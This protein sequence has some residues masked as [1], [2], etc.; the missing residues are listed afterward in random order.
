MH[1]EEVHSFFCGWN[2][3]ALVVS[4]LTMGKDIGRW[5]GPCVRATMEGD[6]E[7]VV[8]Q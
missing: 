5:W 1:P 6:R 8:S 4:V 2:R 3:W 7:M